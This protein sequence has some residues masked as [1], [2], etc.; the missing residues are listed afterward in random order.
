M[1]K[2]FAHWNGLEKDISSVH[3]CCM[4]SLMKQLAL[5]DKELHKKII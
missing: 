3:Q 2:M 4:P 1:K 5:E